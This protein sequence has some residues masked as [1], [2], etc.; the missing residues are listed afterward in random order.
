MSNYKFDGLFGKEIENF[1]QYKEALGYYKNIEHSEIYDLN[2]LNDYLNS[3]NLNKIVMTE[4]MTMGYIHLADNMSTERQHQYECRIRQFS[5]YLKNNGYDD[6]YIEYKS[7]IKRDRTLT[8]YV[9]THEQITR[10]IES[11]DTYNSP[12]SAYDK[13]F[14]QTVFRLLYCTGMRIG[15]VTALRPEDV[16]LVNNVITVHHGKENVSRLIPITDSLAEWL[17]MYKE[18][19]SPLMTSYFFGAL[20]GSQR[21]KRT[22]N[23]NFKKTVKRIG[24]IPGDGER[25]TVHT[26]RHTF[27]CHS[28]DKMIREGRDPYNAL[29]YLSVYLGH[30][31]IKNTE[32]YLKLTE[33]R[34]NDVI[35]AGHYIYETEENNN[36]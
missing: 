10:I 31:S 35:D 26:L 19:R 3:F 32:Y 24:I 16:D 6:I 9:F 34:F 13:L 14:Y 17:Q 1:I 30:K 20:N 33:E 12:C 25:I 11:V 5:K 22:I 21:C 27:A 18:K 4:E 36:D 2:K 8:P 28:L 29:P 23:V 15:E 7:I